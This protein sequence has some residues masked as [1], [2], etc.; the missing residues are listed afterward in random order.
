MADQYNNDAIDSQWKTLAPSLTGRKYRRIRQKFHA[1]LIVGE[2]ME[3][4]LPCEW[5][6]HD[7]WEVEPWRSSEMFKGPH[8]SGVAVAT[9]H[10]VIFVGT[11]GSLLEIF[12]GIVAAVITVLILLLNLPL[13]EYPI[14]GFISLLASVAV[15]IVTVIFL[16]DL[17]S[18]VHKKEV[19]YASISWEPFPSVRYIDHQ[20][21]RLVQIGA[22]EYRCD[23][24]INDRRF[25]FCVKSHYLR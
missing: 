3:S 15:F 16:S 5:G 11:S 21:T 19:D 25:L 24:K 6:T 17:M 14:L 4:I 9:N 1:T 22:Y 18:I 23:D 7:S 20:D 2:V 10:R 13:D 12:I 8:Y